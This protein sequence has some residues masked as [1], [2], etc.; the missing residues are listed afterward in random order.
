MQTV[1][2]NHNS[3]C[4]TC[5]LTMNGFELKFAFNRF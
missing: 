4:L 3:I 1:K 2:L 5:K